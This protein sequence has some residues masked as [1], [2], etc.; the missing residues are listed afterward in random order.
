MLEQLSFCARTCLSKKHNV[1]VICSWLPPPCNVIELNIDGSV[2]SE[3]GLASFGCV[4]RDH[5]GNFLQAAGGIIGWASINT[6][7]L[8]ALKTGLQLALQMGWTSPSARTDSLY[9]FQCRNRIQ[10]ISWRHRRILTQLRQTRQA[11]QSIDICFVYREC[12]SVA[13]LLAK[14]G[15][16]VLHPDDGIILYSKLSTLY[17]PAL[18][19]RHVLFPM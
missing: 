9:V 5:T 14:Y 2:S 1:N 16:G 8:L 6:A 10:E 18:V 7:E 4:F 3:T 11:L 19:V 17:R 15:S 13:D 12:N